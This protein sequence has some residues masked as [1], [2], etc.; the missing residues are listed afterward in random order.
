[1]AG[2]TLNQIAPGG[3]RLGL[4]TS[5]EQSINTLHGMSFDQPLRRTRETIE[6]VKRLTSHETKRVNY[7]GEIFDVSGIPPLEADVPVYNAALGPANRR[8]TGELCDGWIPHNIPF[9]RLDEAFETLA[10]SAAQQERKAS[11]ISVT[12]YVPAAVS[13]RRDEA[14]DLLRAHIAYYV[15]SGEGYRKAVGSVYPDEAEEVADHWNAGNRSDAAA[16]VSDEMVNDL[17][18]AGTAEEARDQMRELV[19]STCVDEPIVV[20]PFQADPQAVKRT[21]VEL[22]PSSY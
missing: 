21:Q 7:S 14:R 5:T 10:E 15:G 22:S 12:P 17:G 4:G 1:M 2:S 6:L 3:F 16:S 18:V 8:L 19:Q 9:S 13:P 20:I 11:E